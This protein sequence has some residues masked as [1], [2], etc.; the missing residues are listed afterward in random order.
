M[1][2]DYDKILTGLVLTFFGVLI[3]IGYYAYTSTPTDKDIQDTY[4]KYGCKRT[5]EYV[6]KDAD[7]LYLCQDG[8]KYKSGTIYQW[9]VQ[10]KRAK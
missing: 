10:D 5:N 1:E 7:V 8:F 3:G 9:A 6:G 4:V 2:D